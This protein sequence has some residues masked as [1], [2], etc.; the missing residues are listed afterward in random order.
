V[1]PAV[2]TITAN[3]ETRAYGAANPALTVSYSG[4]VNGDTT[5]SLA[6][7]PTL[8][9]TATTASAAGAYAI[10]A[11]GATSANYAISYVNGTL[12]V[13]PAALT[14]SADNHTRAYGV[15]NPALTVSY[16]GFANGDT[17]ASLATPPTAT[18]TATAA[19]G[20]GT[21]PITASGATS[22]NYTISYVTGTLTVTPA[23]L[24]V[25]ADNHTRAYGAANPAFRASYGGFVNGD[26][27]A[28]L[29]GTLTFS[30]SAT[31]SSAV[32]A[33][34]ITPSGL[35]SPNYTISYLNG[36][37]TVTPAVL[38]ITANNE[39]RAY[40]A[41]NPALTVSYSGFVN[42]DTAASLATPATATTTATAASGVGTY[43][44]T[45]SGATSANYTISYVTGTLTV[46][47]ATLTITANNET[48]A[49]GA[50]NPAWTVSY[51]GFVNGDTAASLATP[52]TA[53]T[54]ATAASG[55]GT[56][57][58]T[59]GGATSANYTISYATGTLTV[60][61]ATLTITANN[62]TR[63]YGAANPA[64]T[65]SYSGFVNGDT[66]AS[67]TT[68]PTVTTTATTASGVGTYPI[69]ASDAV[70]ANY[71]I[72][73]VNGTLT[74]TPAMLTITA[75]NE[76]RA[77]G[78]ANP[79]LTVSYSGFV[80]GDTAASL[81]TP[82]TVTTTATTASGVG[83]YPIT[84]S[85]AASANSNYT[86]SYV[87]GTLT[88]TPA[89][90]T[91]TANNETR[92][93]GAANP[94]LT[95]SYSG[96]VNGDTAASLATPPTP[97]TTAT[98]ASG[99]GTYPIT[100]TGAVS[101]NYAISYVNGTLTV[102][103]AMLTI[104]ANNETRAYGAANPALTVS[105]S[106]FVNGDTA[107]SLTPPP[108]VT[109]TATTT[110]PP[111]TYPITASGAVSANYTMSYVNGTL[112]IEASSAP[113]AANDSYAT[114][115]DTQLTVPALG[116]LSNDTDVDGATLTAIVVAGPAHGTLTLSANGSFTYM[117]ASNYNGADSFTYKAND[118]TLD[119]N[120]ST[121]TI[122]VNAVNDAPSFTKGADQAL[123]EDPG[124]RSIAWATNVSAGPADEAGQIL[125]FVVSNNNTGLFAVQPTITPDGTL[126]FT[127]SANASGSATV[128]VRLSDNGGNANGGVDT[129]A[130][131][132]F[133]INVAAVNDA[134]SF[135]KGADQTVP[136]DS[137]AKSIA[138]WAT[139]ISAGPPD[140]SGQTLNFIVS[141][142]NATLFSVR[143]AVASNGTLTFT[144]AAGATGVAHV[145]VQ[146]RDNGGTA[147]G[148]VDTSA[149]QTFTVAIQPKPSLSIAD[150]SVVE[151]NSGTRP[152]V[153][154][155]TLSA[156]SSVAVTV[157]YTTLNGTASSLKD[158][159][160]TSGTLTFA[161]GE[162]SKTIT[163]LVNGNTNRENTETFVVRLSSPTNATI[164]RS[165]GMGTIIDDD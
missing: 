106:G 44:I 59:A 2:L 57:P 118:G 157:N 81:T 112:T 14:V 32:G 70:S 27:V 135:T 120:V 26:T 124:P 62:E 93:Y 77:Y 3:N 79:A 119:S 49:Y 153:F 105:Y 20:V 53:T 50:A 67:L 56:Y 6:T 17:A 94:A 113:V 74:V 98:A 122:A 89:V 86:I 160:A 110:S 136:Q 141:D 146:L 156:A 137:G 37:L 47:A 121:V 130:P 164:A 125:N 30:T 63:A 15:A 52:P 107:A 95:V 148:G 76:T 126:T 9:T 45:A 128:T 99:V 152:M 108:S 36:T 7:P 13:T 11:S 90:L 117:P 143:P 155:V 28:S 65:V 10:T 35:T 111:G 42:G 54:T 138:A 31:T 60:T 64:L 96:F 78:A 102:T 140:E 39:T 8:T 101:A 159:Q 80:N 16:S 34:A 82:P 40:G 72:S 147:N 144:P 100:A 24:T 55:V 12:T 71:A 132:T 114:N 104:T 115:E 142:D 5:A 84:A 4:F 83:T 163:V 73:Y 51:S 165:D 85:G 162:T 1:T 87:T 116:V 43:P 21:Y 109:T 19:S 66:A 92:A 58:I 129:S 23:A 131:Q 29:G 151:G 145:T 46:T 134:P 154:T 75:N 61:A 150:A 149:A 97:T 18:T 161:A 33:Y 88:V 25:S 91:I 38:T 22:A 123:N 158:Y 133:A 103:P 41:A 48:R 127:P 68:P 139:N 69:T